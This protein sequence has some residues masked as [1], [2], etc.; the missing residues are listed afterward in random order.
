MIMAL[1]DIFVQIF[2]REDTLCNFDIDVTVIFGVKVWIVWDDM[3]VAES[4]TTTY[5]RSTIIGSFVF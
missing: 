2:D 4:V 3:L 5:D 1:V